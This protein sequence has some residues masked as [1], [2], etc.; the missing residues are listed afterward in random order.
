MSFFNIFGSKKAIKED[1]VPQ[2][3]YYTLEEIEAIACKGFKDNG[4]LELK[5]TQTYFLQCLNG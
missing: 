1:P 3:Q 5:I 2:K 4:V